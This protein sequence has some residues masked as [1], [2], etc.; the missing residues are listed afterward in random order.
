MINGETAGDELGAAV[1]NNRGDIND[2]GID[3]IVISA[4][5]ASPGTR[6]GAGC[7]YVIFGDAGPKLNVNQMLIG[8]GQTIGFN[9]NNLNATHSFYLA[10][11]LSFNVSAQ[12]G[13]F[14]LVANPGTAISNFTQQQLWNNIIQFVHNGGNFAPSYNVSASSP[15]FAILLPQPAN[16]TFI[17]TPVLVNNTLAISN[18]QTLLLNSAYLAATDANS[19]FGS[20]N[21]TINIMQHGRIEQ[22]LVPGV[23]V[24]S[25]LQS[26]IQNSSLQFVHDGSNVPPGYNV[27]I[28]Y[29]GLRDGPKASAIQFNYSPIIGNNQLTIYQG[30]TVTLTTNNLSATDDETLNDDLIFTV[31]N[32][33]HGEFERASAPGVA[34]TSFTQQEVKGLTISFVQDDSVF[35]PS[36][37]L[38]VSD[39]TNSL[40]AGPQPAVI[41]F[42]DNK[43]NLNPTEISSNDNTIR[44]AIIGAGISGAIGFLFLATRLWL[45]RKAAQN[46]KSILEGGEE[47][48]EKEQKDFNRKVMRLIT[49][50]IF[51]RIKTTGC[52]G[53]RGDMDTRDYI[54]AIEKMVWKLDE[55]RVDLNFDTMSALDRGALLNA[56]ARETRRQTVPQ[57]DWCRSK[58]TNFFCSEISPVQLEEKAD[59]I[60]EAVKKALEDTGR[61]HLVKPEGASLMLGRKSVISR[62]HEA[63]EKENIGLDDLKI[64]VEDQSKRRLTSP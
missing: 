2:D 45:G 6:A 14:E 1:S 52:L 21:F 63:K 30:Y 11:E 49:N 56:I 9:S 41:T 38:S 17:P 4:S 25:F 28:N 29:D 23:A 62:L 27:S 32:V 15:G 58:V 55:L 59:A 18:G 20:I 57:R 34:I 13:R 64:S 44:N 60:A 10:S 35:A 36:Y 42:G 47:D 50:K 5:L 46:L 16:V 51:E 39:G 40:P 7:T 24:T 43:N 22:V 61:R 3:D 19:P 26:A 8:E 48:T 37:D 54:A 53:Y 12:H 31:S 33:Q